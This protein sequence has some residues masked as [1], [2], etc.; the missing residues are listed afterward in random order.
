MSS[1]SAKFTY[2]KCFTAR[3][4]FQCFPSAFSLCTVLPW[5]A[6]SKY[7]AYSLK[8]QAAITV[9]V[10][11]SKKCVRGPDLFPAVTQIHH[12]VTRAGQV[13][14]DQ[15]LVS[16]INEQVK[17]SVSVQG[18]SYCGPLS[19]LPQL[20]SHCTLCLSHHHYPCYLH[21]LIC[22]R[23]VTVITVIIITV[24]A[25][26]TSSLSLLSPYIDL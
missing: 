26:V 5:P 15:C 22:D 24:L 19:H 10:Q 9:C 17:S 25:F 14:G 23:H 18:Q 6:L 11:I 21:I 16:A 1:Q 4:W 2:R 8:S 3:N 20:G 13:G 7:L 12:E